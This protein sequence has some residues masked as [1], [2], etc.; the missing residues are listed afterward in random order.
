MRPIFQKLTTS[1][2]EGF[3]FKEIRGR[4]FDCPWH[5]HSECE[6]ILVQRSGGFRMLGDHLAALRPGDLVLIGPRL[7]HI[8]HNDETAPGGAPRVHA[9][10]LQFEANCLGEG[11]M[12]LEAMGPVRRL[13]ERSV[14]GLEVCGATRAR[15]AEL[16]TK[17]GRV[18]GVRRIARFLEIL[19][20]M[21]RSRECR[22]LASPGFAASGNPF[23][24]ERMNRVCRH[25]SERLDQPIFLSDVANLVHL[26]EGAFSRFFRAHTGKTFPAFVNELRI[27]R[28]CRLLAENEM[29]VT[30]IAFAS[31]FGNLSNFNRQF[32][33]LKGTSPSQFRKAVVIGDT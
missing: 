5:F 28:A 2:E 7:P 27:G 11:M 18:S 33:R 16:M 29:N 9:Y 10:L 24:Q 32:L 17:M 20:V 13:L 12:N 8:Y 31:G 4:G 22:T 30:E 15:V 23:D 14:L 6:L 25:I 19:D 26:S 1:P 21:A 3:A